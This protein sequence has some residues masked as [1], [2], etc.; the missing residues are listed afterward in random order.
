MNNYKK[1]VVSVL[2]EAAVDRRQHNGQ[3]EYKS[4]FVLPTGNQL[5]S[6]P[7]VKGGRTKSRYEK[8]M[9]YVMTKIE[10]KIHVIG[11]EE[12]FQIYKWV[13]FIVGFSF[14]L[15]GVVL[16]CFG[17]HIT[18]FFQQFQ[19]INYA[20][21]VF[22]GLF[23]I[24]LL[25]WLSFLFRP[26]PEE[27]MKRKKIYADLRERKKPTFFNQMVKDAA[28]HAEPPVR[29]LHVVAH[30]R[31][32]D[33]QIHCSNWSQFCEE[34]QKATGLPI[35]RQLIRFK[36]EDLHIT[37]LTKKLDVDYGID[38]GDRLFVYNRGGFFTK[39]SPLIKQHSEIVAMS[40]INKSKQ[41]SA[42][43]IDNTVHNKKKTWTNKAKEFIFSGFF[44][45]Y[46]GRFLAPKE[47]GTVGLKNE[48]EVNGQNDSF[49]QQSFTRS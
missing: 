31:K 19:T 14:A 6:A 17:L 7:I 3:E 12:N 2:R 26:N 43:S 29:V 30:I 42:S 18:V 47:S 11:M 4:N 32:K 35:E 25:I 33:Y 23:M 20:A 8:E 40:I 24:P 45:I 44:Y 16:I 38:D 34:I 22:G 13:L 15:G 1:E 9:E 46:E 49:R 36:D 27:R 39:D 41:E 5:M 28:I 10:N 21:L 37:D 48:K